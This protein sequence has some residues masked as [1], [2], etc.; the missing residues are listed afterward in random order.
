[1]ATKGDHEVQHLRKAAENEVEEKLGQSAIFEAKQASDDEHAQ[2]LM[3]ALT[4]NRKA[5]FWSVM[6][7]MS[8]V[9][10]GYDVILI[11]N[12]FAYPEF[13]KKYGSWYG[14]EIGYQ[15]SGPWQTALTMAATTGA[16]FGGLMN[17]F[18][19]SKYGYRWVMI[20]AMGFL[21]CFIFVVFFAHSA[22]MLLVGQILCGFSWGVFATL[23]PAY[24]SEVC[25][26]NLRG[27][28]TTYVNLCWATGQLIAA[29]VLRG[30]LSIEGEMA[31]RIP[32]A[33]QWLW[34][35]PLMVIS[36]LAPESPWFLVRKDRL[37]E[38]RRSIERLSGDKTQDQINA[39]LA[40]MVHTTKVEAGVTSGV[41]YKDCFKGVDL[42]RTEICC[43]AFAG[44]VMSG[45]SFAYTPT[46]F[47]TT[48]GM[49]TAN[50]FELS[51]GAKGMA[52]I[53]TC[54]SWW[55]I[56]HW[57]RRQI[58][59]T[60]MGILTVILF[61]IGI[62]DVSAGKK[63]L[64][65]SGGLCVFWLFIYSLTIGPIT[66]SVISETSSVRLRPLTVVLSRNAYQLVN[67]VSQ[68]LQT[69]MMNPTEWNLRGKAGFFWAATACTIF[70]W[71]FFRLP[72]AKG[73]TYEELDI[74][75]ARG[76][77]AREFSKTHVDAYA[78][79]SQVE[80]VHHATPPKEDL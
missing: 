75:F 60:G 25:P 20:V 64:W 41:S 69:Y 79:S 31:Y 68:V 15:V 18:F 71:S 3:Q 54:L 49:N 1:M 8:I 57:G 21:N 52:F 32:F 24:A 13:Q 35:I 73:R 46:Y 2:T 76:V 42:R 36:Y 7:S 30:C 19:A 33:I 66:Y 45:S 6:I 48:A 61:I 53:G 16:I 17:G 43:I 77:P 22:A 39:Q 55:L 12:F 65:P 34:P 38:A 80:D 11:N 44:Q 67:I 50:A 29:G 37:D 62:L 63:G 14:D 27:Y 40:M 9:M 4:Q 78:S 51:L 23:S 5:V 10:E 70:V 56:T 28:M 58:Y 47:F 26:T 74:L 72:E 59:V